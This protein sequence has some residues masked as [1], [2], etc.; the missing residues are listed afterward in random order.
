MA[1]V[2]VRL[3][4]VLSILVATSHMASAQAVSQ[5]YSTYNGFWN[6][7]TSTLQP[8]TSHNLLAFQVGSITYATGVDNA[9]LTANGVSF[10][11]T[12]FQAFPAPT[13]A[14]SPVSS[15]YIGVGARYMGAGDHPAVV[16]SLN[17]AQYLNDGE[18]GL[19]LGSGV[20]NLPVTDISYKVASIES[21]AISDSIPDILV[22]QMGQPAGTAFDS[23]R[24]VNAYGVTVGNPVAVKFNSVPSAGVG[25]WKFYTTT[26][27]GAPDYAASVSSPGNRDMRLLA[28][29]LS[30]FGITSANKD[31]IVRFVHKLSGA[32]DVAFMAYNTTSLSAT[33]SSTP[34]CLSVTPKIWVR[35]NSFQDIA[36][37]ARIGFW[38]NEGSSGSE[39]SN[40]LSSQQ[41]YFRSGSENG[42]NFNSYVNTNSGYLTLNNPFG[43]SHS[44]ATEIFIVSRTKSTTGNQTTLGFSSL[45]SDLL[46]IFV[47]PRFG[48]NNGRYYFEHNLLLSPFSLSGKATSSI[49][50]NL[51]SYRFS[52]SNNNVLSRNG[53]TDTLFT[54]NTEFGESRAI[55]GGSGNVDIA[56]IITFASGLSDSNRTRVETYLSIKYGLPLSKV[57][58]SGSYAPIWNYTENT[59]F[60]NRMIGIG[61]DDCQQLHQKQ[62][63]SEVDSNYRL[64]ASVGPLASSVA[65]NTAGFTY[66][67]QFIVYGDD[68]GS[69]STITTNYVKNTCLKRTNRNWLAQVTGT[70]IGA[71]NTQIRI[72]VSDIAF[73]ETTGP[74]Q[75]LLLLDRNNNGSYNDAVDMIYTSASYSDGYAVFNNVNWNPTTGKKIRFTIAIK[76]PGPLPPS[77][78]ISPF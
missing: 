13:L 58:L 56:E 24:F 72:K 66:D 16:I 5:V 63:R 60:N 20:F 32:S 49:A 54:R 69:L 53:T 3:V 59:S 75:F 40:A 23:F 2:Y 4:F 77:V 27:E 36:N 39:F 12:K 47:K 19:D 62:S 31:Q 52:P 43:G 55:I 14:V 51:L 71:I 61:R 37:G 9:R 35:G 30:D 68:N 29:K 26:G 21:S 28:Y 64:I 17:L 50:T 38:D 57:Y 67:G 33:T 10:I 41:P 74:N 76:K 11:N 46:S 45:L 22:T 6:S 65:T 18:Q 7:A 78:T 34:G 48:Y 1:K 44:G 70:N 15:T 42:F 8:D 25:N 73:G